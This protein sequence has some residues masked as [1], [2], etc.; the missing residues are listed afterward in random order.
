MKKFLQIVARHFGYDL[1]KINVN[2]KSKSTIQRLFDGRR[3]KVTTIFDVGAH[4]GQTIEEYEKIFPNA[5]F[6]SFEPFPDTYARLSHLQKANVTAFPFGFSDRVERQTFFANRGSATNSLLPLAGSAQTTWGGHVYLYP[7]GA[8]TCEFSTLDKFVSDAQI[9]EIDFLK[10]DVQGAEYKVIEGG[11]KVLSSGVVNVVK[12]EVIL[13]ETYEGQRPLDEYLKRF[14]SFGFELVNI[15]D[16]VYGTSGRLIQV[17][18]ILQHRNF[19]SGR[20]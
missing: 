18:I 5:H 19:L 12:C 17:D 4:E 9:F 3:D 7:S 6:F 8:V 10:I 14:Y 16:H 20:G 11:A 15:C 1:H 2:S 13:A